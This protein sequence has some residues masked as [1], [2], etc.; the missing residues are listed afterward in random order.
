VLT[1]AIVCVLVSTGLVPTLATAG[2]TSVRPPVQVTPLPPV[3]ARPIPVLAP[4]APDA[5]SA[6]DPDDV[7]GPA[8]EVEP[9]VI[10]ELDLPEVP[11]LARLPSGRPERVPRPPFRAV[12]PRA[13]GVSIAALNACHAALRARRYEAASIACRT[14]I[15]AWPGNHRAWF[16]WANADIARRRW[17]AA[18]AAVGQAVALR[19]DLAM[20]QMVYGI[21]LYEAI[22]QRAAGDSQDRRQTARQA[23]VRALAIEPRLWRAHFYLG[24]IE[25]DLH[26]DRAAAEQL[27]TA[28]RLNP[29]HRAG[30]IALSELYRATGHFREALEVADAGLGRL[31]SAGA[32]DLRREVALTHDAINA[33][34]DAEAYLSW[35]GGA[36]W[37]AQ[38]PR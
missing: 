3:P 15:M 1:R 4:H 23:V 35:F 31:P 17:D 5:G 36:A 9:P 7:P 2:V 24:C 26:A 27:T 30:Y 18:R 22:A 29:D 25:R 11:D 12:S 20:Y 28:I 13:R 14:S 33:E 10:A 21:T 38:P 19:P 32:A 37:W 6:P 8:L 34:R 16:G